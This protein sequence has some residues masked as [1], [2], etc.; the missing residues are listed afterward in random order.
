M[1]RPPTPLLGQAADERGLAYT[2]IAGDDDEW[3]CAM[4]VCHVRPAV[5]PGRRGRQLNSAAALRRR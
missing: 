2:D 3:S 4:R 1:R 5:A